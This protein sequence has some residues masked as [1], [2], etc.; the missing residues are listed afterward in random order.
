MCIPH[1]HI[2]K[3][4]ASSGCPVRRDA[5]DVAIS[6]ARL[7]LAPL[8][9]QRRIHPLAI[10][11]PKVFLTAR[12]APER[13]SLF[14]QRVELVEHGHGAGR[15]LR[16]VLGHRMTMRTRM[17]ELSATISQSRNNAGLRQRV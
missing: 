10:G 16:P 13:H 12:W 11:R 15:H 3:R 8:L 6:A 4:L 17:P 7:N 2:E 5:M 9:R 14:P 1:S